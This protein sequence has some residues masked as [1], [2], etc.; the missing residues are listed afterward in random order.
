MTTMHT[1]VFT[2]AGAKPKKTVIKCDAA[3]VPHIM[4]WYGAHH[5]G[6]KYK[7]TIDGRYISMD[8]NGLIFMEWPLMPNSIMAFMI[9]RAFA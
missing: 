5:A 6:D 3:S 7:A 4:V 2:R 9:E 8:K 1:L